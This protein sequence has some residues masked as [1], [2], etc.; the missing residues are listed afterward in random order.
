[1]KGKQNSLVHV[2]LPQIVPPLHLADDVPVVPNR[3]LQQLERL[4][5]LAQLERTRLRERRELEKLRL[6]KLHRLD[7]VL[8]DR[9]LHRRIFP[10]VILLVLLQL[11]NRPEVVQ[12]DREL[13]SRG[14]LVIRPIVLVGRQIR[15]RFV[16][17]V[18]SRDNQGRVPEP[19]FHEHL[20][21][22]QE[23]QKLH[24][25]GLRR[26]HERRHALVVL[27]TDFL[28]HDPVHDVAL[29]RAERVQVRPGA[30]QHQSGAPALVLEPVLMLKRFQERQI[31]DV[32]HHL[33]QKVT[34]APRRLRDDRDD[35]QVAHRDCVFN[36]VFSSRVFHIY[37]RRGQDAHQ[38]HSSPVDRL[39][40]WC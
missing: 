20:F 32:S 7:L 12:H 39:D 18:Q 21:P 13:Q 1:M 38:L 15:H 30:Q 31:F 34:S 23:L 37:L 25:P 4:A 24:V 6:Q 27:L 3:F 22:E 28:G 11:P 19:V 14:A 29:L 35:R 10:R 9:E 17:F 5:I 16:L 36:R 33:N 40:Q 26:V 8:V 2:Q